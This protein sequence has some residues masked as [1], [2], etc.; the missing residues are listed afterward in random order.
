MTI[1]SISDLSHIP[2]SHSSKI[3]PMQ[4]VADRPLSE[5]SI[6]L[7]G[8]GAPTRAVV[9]CEVICCSAIGQQVPPLAVHSFLGENAHR[10]LANA[11]D[12]VAGDTWEPR[13]PGKGTQANDLTTTQHLVRS[14]F[15]IQPIAAGTAPPVAKSKRAELGGPRN[16]P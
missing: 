11:R 14:N 5:N 9:N 10:M 12:R 1:N 15:L 4:V 3:T 8:A 7:A 6:G 2:R 13:S 16:L